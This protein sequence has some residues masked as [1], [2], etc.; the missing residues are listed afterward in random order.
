MID[1]NKLQE[2]MDLI[3]EISPNANVITT[4]LDEISDQ[5]LLEI[6]ESN[7]SFSFKRKRFDT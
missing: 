7:D 2:T 5:Q 3:H 4:K 1:E 6:L